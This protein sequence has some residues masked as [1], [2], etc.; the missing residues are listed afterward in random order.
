MTTVGI[1]AEYNPLHNGH[2]H[3]FNEAKRLSGADTCIVVMSGPFTQRGEPAAVSKQ[4]RTEMALHMG[5]D[6]VLELPAGYAL[7]PA[8]W[9]AFGAVSLLEATGVAD[10]LCFGSEA[11]SLGGLL[12]L[13]EF[14]ADESS[15]LQDELRRR[16]ALGA[17]FPAAFSAAAAAVWSGTPGGPG[18]P[19]KAE[20]LLRQ[21]NNSLGLH[22]LIALRRLGSAIRPLTVPRTGAGFHDPL[23]RGS[24]IASATAIRRLL[25]EGGSPAAYMPEYSISILEREHAA[26][27]G[28]VSLED[29]RSQLR[30]VLVTRT[31]DE[32][33]LLQDMNEGLENRLLK[34]LPQLEQFTVGGL[35]GAL[36]SKRYTQT[37]L[38]RLL[39]HTLLNHSK[40]ELAPSALAQG[41]G[42]IRVLGFRESG[43]RLLKQMKQTA[44]WPVVLSPAQ[45][46][47]P[48][49]ERD[50]RAAAAYAGAFTAPQNKDLYADYLM[51]PVML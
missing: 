43:R 23:Q 47:H 34:V 29:F 28:P 45:F 42:Y 2:V 50:L 13:A 8:E 51:P 49:L 48:G 19:L 21:P 3:H 1:I 12:G 44:A 37:R 20:A 40:A 14:L 7:Q 22:Y 18:S 11:G 9:F 16:L 17:S 39:V 32:L 4:A 30:H 33:R 6:L 35:L 38:Q 24:S 36:K 41:P 26:G 10:S 31:P 27:R 25:Q 15:E 46:S 5:A